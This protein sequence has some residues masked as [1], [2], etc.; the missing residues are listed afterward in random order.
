MAF[1]EFRF[2]DLIDIILVGFL[3][4]KT[5]RMVQGTIA[6]NILIGLF[7]FVVL[8]LIIKALKME[9]SGSI[10]DNFINVGALALIV[11]FQQEIRRFFIHI[12]ARYKLTNTLN[13]KAQDFLINTLIKSCDNMSRNY[14]GALI[15]IEREATLLDY[16]ETGEKIIAIPSP[17]LIESL[18]FKNNPLHDGAIIIKKNMIQAAACILPVSQ[19]PDLPKQMGLRH[20]AAMGIT[21]ATDAI[22]IVV[23]EEKG[24]ISVFDKGS[25]K[26]NLSVIELEELLLKI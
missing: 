12:G 2:I 5:Y 18:F 22:A 15:I 14:T 11:V 23:S 1:L 10:L 17:R 24:T 8:W 21:E 4:F 9:L 3:M 26:L 13:N 19:N 25:Y 7:G 16:V 6:L 20:R